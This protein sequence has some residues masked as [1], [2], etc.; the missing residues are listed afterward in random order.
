M[1]SWKL[2]KALDPAVMLSAKC[3][4]VRNNIIVVSSVWVND[5]V[6]KTC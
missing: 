6:N 1:D 2:Y 3:I 4:E 5:R